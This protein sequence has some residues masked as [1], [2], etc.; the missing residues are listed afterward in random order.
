MSTLSDHNNESARI[1]QYNLQSNVYN[2]RDPDRYYLEEY[3]K[4]RPALNDV[5]V[6]D[7]A[8]A[9]ATDTSNTTIRTAEKVANKDFEVGG[10]SMA[11]SQVTFDS[12]YAGINIATGFLQNDQAIVLPHLAPNQTAWTGTL[13][14]I[15]KEVVW[16][17]AIV[18]NDSSSTGFWAGLKQTN[19][20]TYSSDSHQ[21]FFL[22]TKDATTLGTLTTPANLHFIYSDGSSHY[23]TDLNIAIATATLYKLKIMIDKD[24]K[25]SVY[26]NGKVYGLTTTSGGDGTTV[27]NTG[28]KSKALAT[29]QNLIPYI[30]I[31]TFTTL[32]KSLTV[33]YE[34]ISRV[35]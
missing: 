8:N 10:N 32:S 2:G 24:R 23:I 25:V 3:F 12:I 17:C 6:T 11:T 35:I 15:D 22:Y 1:K 14:S 5:L 4:R 19:V 13:W 31:Q 30:G 29:G 28:Q 7:F 21:A 27:S 20:G 33:C 26:V 34:K 9:N 18:V 16:E